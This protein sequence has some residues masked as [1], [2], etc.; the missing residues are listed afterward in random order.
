MRDIVRA[1]GMGMETVCLSIY[2]RGC[3]RPFLRKRLRVRLQSTSRML[4]GR[5]QDIP[6]ETGDKS[7]HTKHLPVLSCYNWSFPLSK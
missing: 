4:W 3:V 6:L 1:E 2:K 7:A 5:T